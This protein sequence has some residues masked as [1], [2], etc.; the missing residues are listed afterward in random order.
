MYKIKDVDD[1]RRVIADIGD[2]MTQGDR[3]VVMLAP[4]YSGMVRACDYANVATLEKTAGDVKIWLYSR[5]VTVD[6]YWDDIRRVFLQKYL[7]CDGMIL[8]VVLRL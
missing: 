1:L 3:V 2:D 4:V 6:E 7:D 5:A 8:D